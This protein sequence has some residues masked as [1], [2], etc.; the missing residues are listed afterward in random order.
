MGKEQFIMMKLKDS[1]YSNQMLSI[2]DN[3]VYCEIEYQRDRSSFAG[4]AFKITNMGNEIVVRKTEEKTI[5]RVS[6]YEKIYMVTGTTDYQEKTVGAN[7]H[8]ML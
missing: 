1:D 8:I 3:I 4:I 5:K 6:K 7:C 2:E